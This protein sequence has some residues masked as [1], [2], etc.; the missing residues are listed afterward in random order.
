MATDPRDPLAGLSD[1]ELYARWHSDAAP[2]ARSSAWE[3]LY[4]KYRRNLIAYCSSITHDL[5]TAED[6]SEEAFVRLLVKPLDVA[7]SFR[8]YLWKTARAI[9]LDTHARLRQKGP[10]PTLTSTASDP[11]ED[12]ETAELGQAV[13][14]CLA[15]MN[16]HEREF[17]LLRACYDLSLEDAR[18][19]VGWTCAISTCKSRY[20]KTLQALR[21]CLKNR[22]FCPEKTDL[23]TV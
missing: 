3:S 8:A 13:E 18:N 16:P 22:G 4:D 12:C 1:E 15:G 20:D 11:A 17:L 2:S 23:Q 6:C 9:A 14:S 21:C 19:I 5:A 10:M 7:H